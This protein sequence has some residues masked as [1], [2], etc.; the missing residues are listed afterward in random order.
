[1]YAGGNQ[2]QRKQQVSARTGQWTQGL[3]ACCASAMFVLPCAW[4]VAAVVTMMKYMITF[5][6]NT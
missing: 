1:M 2:S 3:S 4:S 6:A 5:E